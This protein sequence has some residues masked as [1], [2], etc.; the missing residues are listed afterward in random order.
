M[1]IEIGPQEAKV[2]GGVVTQFNQIFLRVRLSISV[3]VLLFSVY[4]TSDRRDGRRS[5]FIN[6]VCADEM[7][8]DQLL[9]A[10]IVNPLRPAHAGSLTD[11]IGG[12]T[13]LYRLH[14]MLESLVHGLELCDH[15]APELQHP[16][17]MRVDRVTQC[18][19]DRSR[20]VGHSG[21]VSI[22][23][24]R[25]ARSTGAEPSG[26]ASQNQVSVRSHL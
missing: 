16:F 22:Q 15:L 13:N 7:D 14:G 20:V 11:E 25:A 2:S 26:S 5:P 17:V 8:L 4:F 1:G 19:A 18:Q 3:G 21:S 23:P 6:L 24:I 10:Y 9:L 12:Q